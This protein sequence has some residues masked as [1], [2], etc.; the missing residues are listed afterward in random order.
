MRP[1]SQAL[2]PIA[3][4]AIMLH[5]ATARADDSAAP[6]FSFAGF[7]TLGVVHSSERDAHFT[8]STFKPGGAGL[9]HAWSGDVDS[10][11][12]AQVSAKPAPALSAVLQVVAEQNYDDTWRPH[13]EWANLK[14]Q[15]SPDFNVRVGRT[16]LPIFLV[17]DS[18]KLGYA[19][20]WVRPPLEVYSLVPVTGNDGI[21]A[22]LRMPL[23]DATN[24]LQA[25]VGRSKA[26]FPDRDGRGSGDARLRDLV[27]VADTLSLGFATLHASYGRA[28]LTIAAYDPLFDA[29]RQFGP[30]GIAL[31]DKYNVN[32]KT[33]TFVGVGAAY[34]PGNW[35]VMGE[36][37]TTWSR[38]VFGRKSAWYLTAGH[39]A[40]KFTP[41]ATYARAKADQLSDP[42]LTVAA[43]PPFLAPTAAG[44]NA[45]L[46]SILRGNPVLRTVSVG[47]R[48]D[49]TRKAA[50]KV[51]FD[52]SWIGAGSIGTLSDT[53]AGFQPGGKLD[54]FS[55][56]LDFVF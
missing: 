2:A 41:F 15:F 34:D 28:H 38:T 3:L 33:S 1:A 20:P 6:V 4:L 56:T 45:V 31:A 9:G 37:S 24:A 42:G 10:L 32:G 21:D 49:F 40:G 16:L 19:N 7:G 14:Y 35:F 30:E 44:L 12:A 55:A 54:V 13:V 11:I 5:P 23:G 29:F 48:W 25:S 43:Y 36:W 47:A 17:T 8:S 53:S 22:S 52:R 39:R 18:R 50:I 27:T 26:A 46:D 51:Q